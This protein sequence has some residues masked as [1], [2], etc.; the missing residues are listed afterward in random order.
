MPGNLLRRLTSAGLLAL[1]LGGGGGLP[2]VD[3]VA[4]HPF[5]G[6]Q[7]TQ[8]AHFEAG[9]GCHADQCAVRS[10]SAHSR[11]SFDPVGGLAVAG[12]LARFVPAAPVATPRPT[13]L[14][15]SHLSRA[16]PS[17]F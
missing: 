6:E 12:L 4:F 14:R 2:I 8:H 1:M 15:S 9:S 16:P 3:A 10:T 11:Y 13:T 17:L 7:R 5:D